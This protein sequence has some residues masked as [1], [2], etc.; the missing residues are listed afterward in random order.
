[1][2]MSSLKSIVVSDKDDEGNFD[3]AT[4]LALT[5]DGVDFSINGD[6]EVIEGP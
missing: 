4:N 2:Q 5:L 3:E 1:M 6:G